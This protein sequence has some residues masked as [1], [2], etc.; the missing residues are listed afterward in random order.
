MDLPPIFID[1]DGFWA[2]ERFFDL[3][4]MFLDLNFDSESIPGGFRVIGYLSSELLAISGLQNHK[5]SK[6]ANY[7]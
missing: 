7:M 4:T 5:I 3:V 2:P 6:S 1:F